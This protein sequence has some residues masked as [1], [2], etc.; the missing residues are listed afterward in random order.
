MLPLQVF[1]AVDLFPSVA[2]GNYT[3]R[4]GIPDDEV[5]SLAFL[6]RDTPSFSALV[7]AAQSRAVSI[8]VQY[9]CVNYKIDVPV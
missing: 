7:Y 3:W 2:W 6:F 9:A 4:R 8:Y 5:Y 1:L